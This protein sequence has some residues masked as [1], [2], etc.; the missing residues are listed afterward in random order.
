MTRTTVRYIEC[1]LSPY[2]FYITVAVPWCGEVYSGYCKAW[3]PGILMTTS[4]VVWGLVLHCGPRSQ[5]VSM[6]V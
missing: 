2:G 1:L 6:E 4:Y 3:Y 5:L